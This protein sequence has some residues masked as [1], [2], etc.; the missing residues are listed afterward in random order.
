MLQRQT[1]EKHEKDKCSLLL[2]RKEDGRVDGHGVSEVENTKS[3][4]R[5]TDIPV[6]NPISKKMRV[7]RFTTIL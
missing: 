3:A 2:L 5:Q 1:W 6:L 4:A 7:A